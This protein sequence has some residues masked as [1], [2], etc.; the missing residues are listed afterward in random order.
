LFIA[1]ALAVTGCGST[2]GF[3]RN[4]PSPSRGAAG[5]T[6]WALDQLAPAPDDGSGTRLLY[7]VLQVTTTGGTR[8]IDESSITLLDDAGVARAAV[9][10]AVYVPIDRLDGISLRSGFAVAGTV[11]FALPPSS[12]PVA[13]V[14]HDTAGEVRLGAPG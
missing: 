10:P 11:A 8:V 6:T 2:V 4:A 3:A 14:I 9:K 12:R 1:A 5:D 7:A 13:V